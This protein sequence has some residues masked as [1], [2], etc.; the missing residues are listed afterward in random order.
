MGSRS[1]PALARVNTGSADTI[2]L[3]PNPTDGCCGAASCC[4]APA[5]P[6]KEVLRLAHSET[7]R[8]LDELVALESAAAD[9]RKAMEATIAGLMTEGIS[10]EERQILLRE[11]KA[12][13]ASRHPAPSTS[14]PAPADLPFI[15]RD[16]SEKLT[17][18]LEQIEVRR[19][20][21]R[22]HF[23]IEQTRVKR[24]IRGL[25]ADG[26]FREALTWQNYEAIA[27]ALNPL[28]RTATDDGAHDAPAPLATHRLR[29]KQELLANYLQR[30]CVKADTI[31]FFGPVG[32]GELSES[33]DALSLQVG[34]HL[35]ASRTV[36][37]EF[38][39]IDRLAV[40]LSTRPALRP[41]IAP[42]R[43][44]TIRVEA[45]TLYLPDGTSK[46]I[47]GATAKLL[48][49]CDGERA[50]RDIAAQVVGERL[51]SFPTDTAVFAELA[52]LEQ[53]KL[54]LWAFEVPIGDPRPERMLRRLIARVGD[55]EAR[56]AALAA[57]DELEARRDGVGCS[58]GD[59]IALADSLRQASET[60]TGLTGAE[61]TRNRGHTYAGRTI[62]YEDCRRDIQ[63]E[64]GAEVLA[65][66]KEPLSLVLQSARWFTFTLKSR[67][68]D[69]FATVYRQLR[70]ESDSE[71]AV[72]Y[73]RFWEHVEAHVPAVMAG[74]VSPL[75]QDVVAE[76]QSRWARVLGIEPGQ[77]R[78]NFTS[79]ELRS[80]AGGVF[81][82]PH[83][84]LPFLR[85]H[86]P[87]VMIAATDVDAI[88]RGDFLLVLGELH[89]G[90]NLVTRPVAL[91]QCTH[92]DELI[93]A[94]TED[95]PESEY[96]PIQKKN[97]NIRTTLATFKAT[98]I[99]F[100]TAD[101]R[102]WLPVV[103][104]SQ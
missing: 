11:R 80:R 12:L 70:A 91:E 64:I 65:Q 69:L 67:F 61:A 32:W 42:R 45:D 92:A 3:C 93:R 100:E 66:L 1:S 25:F 13:R 62:L 56:A 34:K 88:R 75:V 17:K 96:F 30:Y 22:A 49:A 4:A 60:F 98:D 72:S 78:Q 95:L 59:P 41:W 47:T 76:L 15:L 48:L 36:Y 63:L 53:Q 58:A 102:S 20:E 52:A 55:Q 74:R 57:L 10:P 103:R 94:R 50:A 39:A 89:A 23:A 2:S 84:G 73:L 44:P 8:I 16:S 86:S 101:A 21:A 104:C 6:A 37:F 77:R 97:S 5:S 43:M 19:A 81:A 24:E 35:L 99:H 83:S 7:S 28:L 29:R 27:T 87:D 79:N 90:A 14:T 18:T 51:P 46:R 71:G 38:W 82:A 68:E 26:P 9:A 54:V 40:A 31:G 33:G 85:H